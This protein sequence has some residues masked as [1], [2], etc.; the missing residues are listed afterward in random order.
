M[1]YTATPLDGISEADWQRWVVDAAK[2]LG[3][4]VFHPRPAQ[5]AGRWATHYTGDAGFPDLC[6]VHP[7]KGFVL[8]E[9]KTDRGKIS[10]GQRLWLDALESA[11]VEA[12]VW[13]PKDWQTVEKRL[14]SLPQ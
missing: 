14:R 2:W 9:L 6:L 8:A 5:I 3:W 12:Y 4:R 7:R 11:G 13:R 10:A 1:A